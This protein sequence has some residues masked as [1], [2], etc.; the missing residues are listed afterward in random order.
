MACLWGVACSGVW[1]WRILRFAHPV[2]AQCGVPDAARLPAGFPAHGHAAC[3]GP[4][5]GAGCD[6]A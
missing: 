5:Q 1:S 4:E 2:P 6:A 3:A